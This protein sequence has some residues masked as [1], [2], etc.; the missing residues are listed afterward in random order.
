MREL[1]VFVCAHDDV[2]EL[3]RIDAGVALGV[4]VSDKGSKSAVLRSGHFLVPHGLLFPFAELGPEILQVL[5]RDLSRVVVIKQLEQLLCH[6]HIST[7]H[8][9]STSGGDLVSRSGKKAALKS[10]AARVVAVVSSLSEINLYAA[11]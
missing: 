10:G 8:N 5:C 11:G 3:F 2:D 4:E 7:K 6:V 9:I 1:E